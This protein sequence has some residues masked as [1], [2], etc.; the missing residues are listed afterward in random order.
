MPAARASAWTCTGP[1]PASACALCSTSAAQHC[2]C[3]V[4]SQLLTRGMGAG[5]PD[6]VS[7][8]VSPELPFKV[9]TLPRIS[10]KADC[11]RYHVVRPA[12]N[13]QACADTLPRRSTWPSCRKPRSTN[14]RL[15]RWTFP[16]RPL[17]FAPPLPRP[18]EASLEPRALCLGTWGGQV[19]TVWGRVELCKGPRGRPEL[20]PL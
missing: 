15:P 2:C 11:S 19:S 14:E 7:T 3:D 5:A 20:R 9:D 1:Q 16:R 6:L 18:G 8:D 13:G 17:A 10:C 4:S 12:N